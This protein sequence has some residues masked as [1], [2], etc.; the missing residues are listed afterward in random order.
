MCRSSHGNLWLIVMK[1]DS[2]AGR[3]RPLP[4]VILVR[5]SYHSH[6]CLRLTHHKTSLF[7][8]GSVSS[9][10]IQGYPSVLRVISARSRTLEH[11]SHLKTTAKVPE[12]RL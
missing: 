5:V 10:N 9:I 1:I 3:S 7:Q 12:Y 2:E 4:S 8:Q 6:V 11:L